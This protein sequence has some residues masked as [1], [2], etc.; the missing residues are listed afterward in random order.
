MPA[1]HWRPVIQN[2]S[3]PK[4]LAIVNAIAADIASGVLAPLQKLPAQR[5]LAETLGIHFTTVTRAY[6]EAHA[7][8]LLEA[9]VGAGSFVSEK[10][11]RNIEQTSSAQPQRSVSEDRA[12]IDMSMNLPPEPCDVLLQQRLRDN[13][14]ALGRQLRELMRYQQAGGTLTDR[15]VA[16]EWLA[17]CI[18]CTPEQLVVVPGAQAALLAIFMLLKLSPGR[19]LY[20]A[21]LTYPGV[22]RA[23]AQ[24]NIPL[25]GLPF[26]ADGIDPVAF[27]RACQ[28]QQVGALY[29]NPVLHNPTAITMSLKRRHQ[30]AELALRYQVTIIEDDAYG[31]LPRYPLPPVA[32]LAPHNTWYIAGLAKCLG[33]GL[34]VAYTVAPSAAEAQRLLGVLR[35]TSVMASP[36]TTALASQWIAS[37]TATQLLEAIRTETRYRREIAEQLLPNTALS[38]ESDAFHLWL[39]LPANWTRAAFA[40][41]LTRRGVSVVPSDSFAVMDVPPEAVRLSLGGAI[42]RE[43]LG[44]A[45]TDIAATLTEDPASGAVVI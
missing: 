25:Y 22:K 8:G 32:T 2:A 1:S 33:A 16:C 35:A 11:A 44:V 29:L 13:F 24:L 14:D 5:Q 40:H 41:H 38:G 30:I 37:G 12:A 3:G 10:A 18:T 19:P 6:R 45:L 7:R 28:Q 21:E 43:E 15:A 20:C 34:R 9:R 26:D 27:E 17:P 4:Y 42:S 39:R 36:L 31:M 23:A